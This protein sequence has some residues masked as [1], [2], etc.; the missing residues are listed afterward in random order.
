M[1][2]VV[3]LQTYDRLWIGSDSAVSTNIGGVT[4]RWHENGQKLWVVDDSVIFCSGR[5]EL[6]DRVMREFHSISDRSMER[7]Q[8]IAI[9]QHDA[10][11]LERGRRSR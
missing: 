10:Y 8:E 3:V 7:L 6:A 4:Y 11:L 5:A 2:S 1:S 9:Q